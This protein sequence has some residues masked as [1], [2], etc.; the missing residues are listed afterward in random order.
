MGSDL[1]RGWEVFCGRGCEVTWGRGVCSGL[2]KRV[3]SGRGRS[4]RNSKRPF[5]RHLSL[6]TNQLHNTLNPQCN[7]GNQLFVVDK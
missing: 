6:M 1:G 4:V 3:G 7:F 5:S 2:G